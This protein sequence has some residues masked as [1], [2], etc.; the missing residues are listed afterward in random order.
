MKKYI[1]ISLFMFSVL[2]SQ[3][4]GTWEWIN[5]YPQGSGLSD[6][7]FVNPDTGYF[8]GYYGTIIKTTDGAE[9]YEILNSGTTAYFRSL[10][11]ISYD[12]GFVCGNGGIV[13]RTTDAGVRWDT[14]YSGITRNL[15]KIIFLDKE[16]GFI[17]GD[18]GIILKT[19]DGGNSW[20]QIPTPVS[21]RIWDIQFPTRETGYA[22]CYTYDTTLKTTDFGNTWFCI[23]D[24]FAI[25]SNHY[26]TIHFYNADTG[27]I[28][29]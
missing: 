16:I 2:C 9:S 21:S 11:F 19:M 12:T 13:M 23:H 6:I 20:D 22:L 18:G 24:N 28:H 29:H 25:G 4:Q 8:A 1:S 10:Y 27:F 26:K 3:S 7:Y 17:V 14:V 5:S 15:Y